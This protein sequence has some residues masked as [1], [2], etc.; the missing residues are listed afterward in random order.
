VPRLI[1]SKE[2]AV[3]LDDGRHAA[4]AVG[5]DPLRRDILQHTDRLLGH[6]TPI[7]SVTRVEGD[8]PA[9]MLVG[10]KLH[11]ASTCAQDANHGLTHLGSKPVGQAA[12]EERDGDSRCLAARQP[13]RRF[14][15]EP[16]SSNALT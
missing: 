4:G 10:G 14:N 9:A 12:R 5:Q 3:V 8:K 1:L 11:I 16:V 7:L 6:D 15:Q 13:W 2:V